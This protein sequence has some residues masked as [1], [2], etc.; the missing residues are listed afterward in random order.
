MPSSVRLAGSHTDY[1]QIACEMTHY[2]RI[3]LDIIDHNKGVQATQV[4]SK[5][6]IF[7][8]NALTSSAQSSDNKDAKAIRRR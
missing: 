4:L 2:I 7:R 3:I 8:A 1:R 5:A 6:N